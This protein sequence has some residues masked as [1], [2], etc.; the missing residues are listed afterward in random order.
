MEIAPE[1]KVFV[2]DKVRC[3]H[4]PAGL[5][6]ADCLAQEHE[7]RVE[8]EGDKPVVLTLKSGA[9]E[10]FG[11]RP[12]L[13]RTPAPS[14]ARGQQG[15]RT[16]ESFKI[17]GWFRRLLYCASASAVPPYG[18]FRERLLIPHRGGRLRGGG[19]PARDTQPPEGGALH[20]GRRHCRAGGQP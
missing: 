11:A 3:S 9:A 19:G 4:T 14:C 15:A 2:L 17:K 7:L 1:K 10:I 8:A 18:R 12:A 6:A 16:Q 5:A 20:L 13:L